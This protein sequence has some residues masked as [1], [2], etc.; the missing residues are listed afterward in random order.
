[1]TKY[2]IYSIFVFAQ[3]CSIFGQNI[4]NNNIATIPVAYA[5]ATEGH[6]GSLLVGDVLA[7]DIFSEEV[8]LDTLFSTLYGVLTLE[9]M[10]TLWTGNYTYQS[11]KLT[12]KAASFSY[13]ICTTSHP[14]RCDTSVVTLHT[15]FEEG[16][17]PE[18]LSPNNDGLSDTFI[19]PELKD[20]TAFPNNKIAIF[21]R[22]G[23]VVFEQENYQ[24]TWTGKHQK[25]E[26]PLSAATYYYVVWLDVGEEELRFGRVEVVR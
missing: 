15:V 6:F 2:L 12:D 20:L 9:L 18:V 1:M 21:N 7:N 4:A 11:E 14:K 26:K 16:D 17:I 19:V 23:D 22:K 25:T 5:D 13:Q 24:N 10:D 8:Q 3:C